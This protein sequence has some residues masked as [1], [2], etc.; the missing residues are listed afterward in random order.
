MTT[1]T[2]SRTSVEIA[3]QPACWRQ[4]ASS[5]TRHACALPRRGERVAVIGCGTSWFMAQAYAVLRESGGHGVTDAFAAS[6]F[7]QGRG[8]YDRILAISRSGT[9]TEVLDLLGRARAAGVRT[10]AITADPATPI[11]TTA[12]DVAV[13]DFADEESV[14]QTRFATTVLALLRAHLEA[15]GALPAGVHT[16]ARAADDA[17][18]AIGTPLAAEVCGAE[19]IT[20]LGSG[21]TYGLALEAGLKMREAAGAWTEAYPAMEYR[22]GPISITRPGRVA[23]MFG[24]LPPGLAGDIER[25]GGILVADSQDAAGDLDPLA[26]LVRAQRLAVAVAEARGYDPDR[27]LNLTRS[28]V[29]DDADA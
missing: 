21:W 19:Q 29:L 7:P 4:A 3:S 25:V 28:V 14:V 9:T 26:D 17:E 24:S 5:L 2:P 16:L 15:E 1:A 11:M 12:D 22:H 20:F 10:A 6:E 27:P 23:W 8:G 18:R 13:L